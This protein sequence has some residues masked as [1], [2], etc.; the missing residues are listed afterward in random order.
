MVTTYL[1][2]SLVDIL[3]PVGFVLHL[4]LLP[5]TSLLH[6]SHILLWLEFA[7]V[8]INGWLVVVHELMFPLGDEGL[9]HQR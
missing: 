3:L 1:S 5:S 7:L 8:V 2:G 9:V 6:W 4:S